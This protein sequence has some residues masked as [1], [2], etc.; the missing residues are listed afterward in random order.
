MLIRNEGRK[1]QAPQNLDEEESRESKR[2]NCIKE[3]KRK[4]LYVFKDLGV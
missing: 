1:N 4:L 3:V 2:G